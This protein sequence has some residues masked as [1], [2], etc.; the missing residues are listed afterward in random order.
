[1]GSEV[2]PVIC[3]STLEMWSG[4]LDFPVVSI[5]I[6]L[7]GSG[8]DLGCNLGWCLS[9]FKTVLESIWEFAKLL[10]HHLDKGE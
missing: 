6:P 9:A 8:C 7:Q 4:K 5:F 3:S 1:M 2:G 10:G